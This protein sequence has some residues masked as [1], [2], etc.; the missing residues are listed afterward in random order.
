MQQLQ[1]RLRV[2]GRLGVVDAACSHMCS[3]SLRVFRGYI[4]QQLQRRLCVS[5]R[6]GVVV[7]SCSSVSGGH[8]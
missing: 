8:L 6:L 1:R 3:R 4:V 7:A 5:G 2:S